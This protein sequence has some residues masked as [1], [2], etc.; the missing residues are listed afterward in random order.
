MTRFKLGV[1]GIVFAMLMVCGCKSQ[2]NRQPAKQ[3]QPAKSSTPDNT[4]AKP[5]CCQGR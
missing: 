2:D 4:K 1:C 5:P 3:D